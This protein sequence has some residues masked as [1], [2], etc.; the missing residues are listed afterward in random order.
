MGD[1]LRHNRANEKA[2]AKAE[3]RPEQFPRGRVIRGSLASSTST[4]SSAQRASVTPGVLFDARREAKRVLDAASFEA[5]R[6][7]IEAQ[8]E[9][10]DIREAARA[11]GYEDGLAEVNELLVRFR[12]EREK[13]LLEHK[14]DVVGLA[15]RVAGKIL[16]RE[17]EERPETFTDLVIRAVRGIRHEK[18]I[19]IR[20]HPDDLSLAR[21]G[22]DRL[23]DE[24]GP[25]KEIE[26]REDRAVTGGGCVVETDLGIIDARLETQLKTLEKALVRGR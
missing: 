1:D 14:G 12:D 5:E 13:K 17:I 11:Q 25:G 15:V 21:A 26:I 19:Q 20:V 16:G 9:A 8:A 18:R 22:L 6:R 2:D 10:D 24:V 4:A 3:E 7:V 23:R